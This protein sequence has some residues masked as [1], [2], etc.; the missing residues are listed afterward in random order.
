MAP[1]P[2][3][4]RTRDVAQALRAVQTAGLAARSLEIDKD[5]KII[6]QIGVSPAGGCDGAN[7]EDDGA[8][9]KRL[10]ELENNKRKDN[11]DE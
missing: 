10:D 8:W 2:L 11:R 9:E 4:Y 7:D 5:G 3:T 6:V 1:K